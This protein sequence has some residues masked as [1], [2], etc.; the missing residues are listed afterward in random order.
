MTIRS[1]YSSDTSCS[2][3]FYVYDTLSNQTR[4]IFRWKTKDYDPPVLSSPSYRGHPVRH[5]LPDLLVGL[6]FDEPV[7]V[8]SALPNVLLKHYGT[9]EV[10]PFTWG[11]A[12]LAQADTYQDKLYLQTSTLERGERYVFQ[13]S[14][15]SWTNTVTSQMKQGPPIYNLQ[16]YSQKGGI[17]FPRNARTYSK[18]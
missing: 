8:S 4:F 15:V 12:T 14:P 13:R 18:L 5:G 2:V 3:N 6:N 9:G 16:I 17:A 7:L 11:P 1:T 10:L